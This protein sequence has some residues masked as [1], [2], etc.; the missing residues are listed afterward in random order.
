MSR[1][2]I[3]AILMTTTLAA[4]ARPSLEEV[5]KEMGIPSSGEIRG[6]RDAVGYASSPAAM[7]KVW[8]LS[9]Q[10]PMPESF[11]RPAP[12]PGVAAVIG[13]HDDYVYAGRV[14]RQAYPLV[15]ARTVV[16]I[17]VFHRYRRFDSRD[18]LV[19]DPYRS[20]RSPDGEIAVSPLRDE[21][22]AA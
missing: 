7:A 2:L 3:A 18:Q 22:H 8:E 9:A 20:W 19:F 12:A 11:G 16:V 14:Y 21:L 6:Q 4:T 17:G 5:R 10:G 13:P 1:T 15:T